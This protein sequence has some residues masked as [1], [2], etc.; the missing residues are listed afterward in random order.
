MGT[1]INNKVLAD[2]VV[3][4]VRSIKA[5]ALGVQVLAEFAVDD[6]KKGTKNNRSEAY[7]RFYNEVKDEWLTSKVTKYQNVT[8]QRSYQNAVENRSDS[9]IPY[10]VEAPKGKAW[11]EGAEGILLHSISD[12]TKFYLRI[13]ENKNTKRETTYYVNN[14]EA[15]EDEIEI[16][17]AYLPQ[18]NY[19][20]KKQVEYGVDAN[21]LVVVKDITLN[22]IIAIKFGDRVLKLK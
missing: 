18:K 7:K 4:F 15:T 5:N 6:L 11:V 20:C 8:L 1:P 22:N 14:V 10:E 2:L 13:S 3:A 17:K 12:P 21:N 19:T 9:D 16:I